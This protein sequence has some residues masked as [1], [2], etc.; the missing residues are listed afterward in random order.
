MSTASA[1]HRTEAKS[2]FSRKT[3]QGIQRLLKQKFSVARSPEHELKKKRVSTM[4]PRVSR[5]TSKINLPKRSTVGLGKPLHCDAYSVY[6][7]QA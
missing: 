6:F 3:S 5:A 4:A 2:R 1:A 7:S